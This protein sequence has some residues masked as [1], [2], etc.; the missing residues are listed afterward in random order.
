MKRLNTLI[1]AIFLVTV[2]LLLFSHYCNAQFVNN[3]SIITVTS[4]ELLYSDASFINTANGTFV[5]NG[6]VITNSSLNNNAGSFLSGNGIY[7]MQTNFTNNGNFNAGNSTLEFIGSGNSSLKNKSGNIYYLFVN[8]NENTYINML[9]DEQV[10]KSVV[11]MKDKNWIYLNTHTLTLG[12]N[13][14]VPD[15]SNKRF[16]VTNDSGALIKKDIGTTA[17]TFPVGFN[18]S[19]FNPVYI[20]ENGTPGD[21][22]VRC[23]QNALLNGATGDAIS[24]NGIKSSWFINKTVLAGSNA[25]INARWK[26][27][28]ELPG[29]DY[30]HCMVVRYNGNKWDFNSNLTGIADGNKFHNISRNNNSSFGYF[31]VVSSTPSFNIINGDEL[32]ANT[33]KLKVYPTIVQNNLN[34][35]VPSDKSIKTMNIN[36][37]DATGKIIWQKQNADFQPQHITLPMLAAGMYTVYIEYADKKFIQKIL[38]NQ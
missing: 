23:L 1:K 12:A 11:F 8:K 27:T 30:T 13:C 37:L 38:V 32:F 28:D 26:N 25:T 21:Y 10:L 20:I 4:G 17:F 3:G 14:T 35:D 36:I 9:D 7:K 18:S 2:T 16:F 5:N 33:L 34:I 15:Y 22:S 24:A 19:T 6:I 29:F 31:T